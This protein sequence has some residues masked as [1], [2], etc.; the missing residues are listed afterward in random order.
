MRNDYQAQIFNSYAEIHADFL[1]DNL[2]KQ[3]WFSEYFQKNYLIHFQGLNPDDNI[4]EIGCNKGF[5]LNTLFNNGFR[6]L[7]GVDLSEK[8]IIKARE[9]V[10]SAEFYCMEAGQYLQ[11]QQGKFKCIILKAVLEHVR[12]E[13]TLLFLN[14]I[15]SALTPGGLVLID[16]PNMDWLFSAHERYMDFTHETGYTKESLSQLLR[17]VYGNATVYRGLS[18]VEK[19]GFR[20]IIRNFL[21]RILLSG[22]RIIFKLIEPDSRDIWWENRSLIGVAVK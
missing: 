19:K 18:C 12:K 1:D 16:V 22:M 8:D 21:S 2:E 11:E 6:N 20:A 7:Y 10:P 9:Y 4:L 14:Q 13:D 5:L 15:K 3:E 17:M